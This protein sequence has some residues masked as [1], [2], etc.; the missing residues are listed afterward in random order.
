MR[1]TDLLLTVILHSNTR[2]KKH[3]VGRCFRRIHDDKALGVKTPGDHF[4]CNRLCVNKGAEL[5]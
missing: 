4:D 2:E 3:A 1:T 5:S